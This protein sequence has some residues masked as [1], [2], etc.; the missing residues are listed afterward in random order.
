MEKKSAKQKRLE[1]KWKV[2]VQ[3]SK[4]LGLDIVIDKKIFFENFQIL[5]DKKVGEN[6]FEF[7]LERLDALNKR[8]SEKGDLPL[9]P[10]CDNILF[11][12]GYTILD[13]YTTFY[14]SCTSCGT[15]YEFEG[16]GFYEIPSKDQLREILA[17]VFEMLRFCMG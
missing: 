4:R 8:L 3:E 7:L 1:K 2:L 13:P 15:S 9:C 17:P 10:E 11:M 6:I 12:T 14:Y 5:D 16:Y